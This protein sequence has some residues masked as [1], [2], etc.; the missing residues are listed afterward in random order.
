MQTDEAT[1]APTHPAAL[2]GRRTLDC[3]ARRRLIGNLGGAL[4]ILAAPALARAQDIPPIRPAT[5]FQPEGPFYPYDDMPS[6]QDADLVRVAGLD[7]Q[8]QGQVTHLTGVV[9]GQLGEPVGSALVEIWQCDHTGRYLHRD[10]PNRDRPRDPGFQGYGRTLTDQGGAF[11][12][13]TLKPVPYSSP[14]PWGPIHRAP[15]IHVAVSTR[16]VR[17]LTTQLYVAGDPGN[18]TDFA[19]LLMA[20]PVQRQG[21]IRPYVPRNDIE[22]GALAAHYDLVIAI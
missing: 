1:T 2:D 12:F 9:H 15:H 14:S 18:E 17:R 20:S 6:D 7:A 22:S 5:V 21:I 8:A 3:P 16:G 11:R 19:L 4:T 13:R 10:D